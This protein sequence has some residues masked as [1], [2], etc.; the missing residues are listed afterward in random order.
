VVDDASCRD[1]RTAAAAVDEQLVFAGREAHDE[2]LEGHLAVDHA[3]DRLDERVG[4][5]GRHRR[6]RLGCVGAGEGV[7]RAERDVRDRVVV[8]V[9][10]VDAAAVDREVETLD[11][12]LDAQRR[13]LED[14]RREE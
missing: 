5:E 1:Q 12:R 9:E 8:D 4:S 6:H 10:D 11:V 3:H 14:L 13:F 2:H 7:A